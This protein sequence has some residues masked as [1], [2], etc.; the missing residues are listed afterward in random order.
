MRCKSEA[1]V[2]TDTYFHVKRGRLKLREFE[3]DKAELIFYTRKEKVGPRLSAYTILSISDA[4]KT[5]EFLKKAFGVSVIVR[6]TRHVYYYKEEARIHI[7]KVKGLG[8]F[9][10]FEVFCEGGKKNAAVLYNNLVKIFEI[11]K[12]DIIRYSYADLIRH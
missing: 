12:K 1:L 8:M 3:K 2:Q 9:I 4:K 7:D 10:E 6:K 11:K 5:K